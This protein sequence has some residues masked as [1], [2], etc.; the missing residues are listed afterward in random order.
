M[1]KIQSLIVAAIPLTTYL[2]QATLLLSTKGLERIENPIKI[3]T[4]AYYI[5]IFSVYSI[6]I[7][8]TIFTRLLKGYS[9]GKWIQIASTVQIIIQ[10]VLIITAVVLIN[11]Q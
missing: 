6:Q 2:E 7:L 3:V 10:L 5:Y 9:R 4:F 11:R 8:R 1:Q